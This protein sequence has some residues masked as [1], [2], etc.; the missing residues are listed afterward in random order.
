M[1]LEQLSDSPV[2]ITTENQSDENP[3]VLSAVVEATESGDQAPPLDILE[4]DILEILGSDP[5][6]TIQFAKDIHNELATRLEHIATTGLT[7]EIRKELNDRYLIPANCVKI[8]APSMNPEIKAAVT[9]VITKRD[10]GI[11]ARQK[12]LAAAISGLSSVLNTELASKNKNNERLKQLMDVAR[13]LCDIQHSESITRRNFATFS[14]KNELKDHLQNTKIDKTLFGEDLA[15][16]LKSAKAV[17]K[18]GSELKPKYQPKPKP[19]TSNS[20]TTNLNWKGPAPARRQ[21]GPQRNQGN[22][23]PPPSAPGPHTRFNRNQTH[24]SSSKPS[25]PPPK[26]TRRR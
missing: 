17:S 10:K 23:R 16:T 19:S 12:Q 24:A 8:G 22:A 11:E 15:E 20:T 26:Q 25:L 7:K 13:I 3:S 21:Q 5:S 9:E 1:A 14:V 2:V 4:S 18:S 6:A